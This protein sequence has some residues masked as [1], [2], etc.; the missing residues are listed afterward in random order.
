MAISEESVERTLGRDFRKGVREAGKEEAQKQGKPLDPKSQEISDMLDQAIAAPGV[1]VLITVYRK[2]GGISSST[3]WSRQKESFVGVIDYVTAVDLKSYS[4][5]PIVM[6]YAGGGD[7]RCVIRV[8]QLPIEDKEVAFSVDGEPIM[9][10]P[11]RDQLAAQ[12]IDWRQVQQQQQQP[13]M[14]PGRY[15]LSG[16]IPGAQPQQLPIQPLQQP[17]GQP[18]GY[19]PYSPYGQQSPFAPQNPQDNLLGNLMNRVLDQAKTQP[20]VQSSDDDGMRV[21]ADML[22]KQ[23]N[24]RRQDEKD[25][26]H[27]EEVRATAAETAR[28]DAE[29]DRREEMKEMERR[30]KETLETLTKNNEPK[31][32]AAAEIMTALAPIGAAMIESFASSRSAA[33]VAQADMMKELGANQTRQM[34]ASSE[35]WKAIMAQPQPEDRMAKMLEATGKSAANM[36]G[37]VGTIV[38]G[39]LQEKAGDDR[40]WYVDALFKVLEEGGDLAKMALGGEYEDEEE[41][42]GA[43]GAPQRRLGPP[44]GAQQP[45]GGTDAAA[46]ARARIAEA[47]RQA[48]ARRQAAQQGQ[49]MPAPQARPPAAP[50]Q[51]I[52]VGPD[53]QAQV[54]QQPQPQAGG[55]PS[56]QNFD[57]AMQYILGLIGTDGK[58]EEIAFRMWKHASSGVRTAREWFAHGMDASK[59]VLGSLRDRDEI[60]VTDER[61]LEVGNAIQAYFA[62]LQGG[63][64]PE[65]YL[66][67]HKIQLRVPR[68]TRVDPVQGKQKTASLDG[69]DKAE[70]GESKTA[71]DTTGPAAEVDLGAAPEKEGEDAPTPGLDH[72]NPGAAGAPV[73]PPQTMEQ[74]VDKMTAAAKKAGPGGATAAAAAAGP[75]ATPNSAFGKKPPKPVPFVEG[76]KPKPVKAKPPAEEP[77]EETPPPAP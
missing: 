43:E 14:Q 67:S 17:F 64:N 21:I 20:V 22:E 38:T 52:D 41:G 42:E 24:N 72:E 58:P 54:A 63:G 37:L 4:I 28:K 50:G 27:A 10:K 16:L 66:M 65:E 61:I 71:P 29:R 74:Q 2:G 5:E 45:A 51:V 8:P 12:G 59:Y 19:Q 57:T 11:Q 77:P 75:V 49:Q 23:E 32:N 70:F 40:P 48:K 30:H 68:A 34:E 62:F 39:I 73:K 35:Q 13:S 33:A 6:D 25:R 53:G 7:Y 60:T 46:A 3:A 55:P 9:L 26:Q 76:K 1:Q 47:A 36:T 18:F 44:P 56:I 15:N 31:S 69:Q